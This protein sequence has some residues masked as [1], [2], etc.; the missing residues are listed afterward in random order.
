[1]FFSFLAFAEKSDY[2]ISKEVD[3]KLNQ[4]INFH[5]VDFDYFK[6]VDHQINIYLQ[7]YMRMREENRPL[8]LART[9]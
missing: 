6:F 2:L 7:I 3:F 5:Q 4:F 9:F 1:M 8:C